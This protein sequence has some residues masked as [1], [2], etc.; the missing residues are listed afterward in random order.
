MDIFLNK[1]QESILG[2]VEGF[3]RIIFKG[4]LTSMFPD[5]AFGRYLSKRGVLLK[6]AGKFFESETKTLVEHAKTTAEEAGRPYHFLASAHTHASGRSKEAMARAIA[7]QDGI[8]EGLVCIF[9]VIEP[10][11]SFAV[12]GNRKTQRLEV[13]RRNRR[14][15]HLY[16]YLID[17]VFGWMHVRIQTWAPYAT[18]IYVNGREWLCRQLPQVGV[19]F[20]RSDNKIL[21]VSDFEATAA[22]AEQFNHTDWPAFLIRQVAS[23]NPLLPAIAAAK[24]DGYWFGIDQAEVATDILFKSRA[25]LERIH[26]DLVHAAITGFGATDVMRFLGQKPHHLFTGEVVIDSKKRPE[27]CRIKFRIRRNSVKLYDHLNVLRIETT[28]NN[29]A[30]FKILTSSENAEG[31]VVCRWSPMRKGVSNFWRYAEVAHGANSRLIDALANAPLQGQA[32]EAIDRL[33]RSQSKAGRHVAAFNPVTAEN[34]ALFTAL[35]AGEF[36]INGFRNRDLQAKLYSAPANNPA[37]IKRRTHRTSRLIAKLR[38]HGLI[39]KVTNSRLYR[40]TQNGVKAMWAAVRCRRIDF[41]AAFNMSE[42]FAQ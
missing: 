15:L 35:L 34:V 13:V 36:A 33:C 3:D 38:G 2:V 9:S 20:E 5:G 8:A 30:E 6:D 28:L 22:L 26:H 21:W 18:Q 4:Y 42:S 17:P 24:F 39:A 32:I 25:N 1:H 11:V 27:G 7:E 41:P 16:W 14:C 23:V 31:Q 40:V 19:A 37:E 12:A 29:P 10:C